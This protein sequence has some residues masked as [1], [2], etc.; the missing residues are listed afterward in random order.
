MNRIIPLLKAFAVHLFYDIIKIWIG[1]T[2]FF[3]AFY[4]FAP[5]P[6][7]PDSV[8]NNI[9]VSLVKI[10]PIVSKPNTESIYSADDPDISPFRE[11]IEKTKAFPT[12]YLFWFR[13]VLF[14]EFGKPL[15]YYNSQSHP[16]IVDILFPF[17][18]TTL[19]LFLLGSL[20]SIA[21]SLGASLWFVNRNWN[22]ALNRQHKGT[23]TIM[24]LLALFSNIPS[25]ILAL[26]F[27]LLIV[28]AGLWNVSWVKY[29]VAGIIVGFSDGVFWI[30]SS[31][32]IDDLKAEY[33]KLYIPMSATRGSPNFSIVNLKFSLSVKAIRNILSQMVAVFRQRISIIL[34]M[35][36]IIEVVFNIQGLGLKSWELLHHESNGDYFQVMGIIA[37]FSLLW[38]IVNTACNFTLFLKRR[39]T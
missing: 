18:K 31:Y 35:T 4:L 37:A 27:M 29:F 14:N 32:L 30:L 15:R 11:V 7:L 17:F 8:R 3:F 21:F 25:C 39:E 2:L 38:I 24:N 19:L 23:T 9:N 33:R 28:K 1:I 16:S 22:I 5:T 20:L 34:G 10:L 6:D 13:H 36:I 12:L 26:A